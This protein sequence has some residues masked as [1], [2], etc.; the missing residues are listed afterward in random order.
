MAENTR[1]IAI[2]NHDG[3][4]EVCQV[5]N[6]KELIYILEELT[7]HGKMNIRTYDGLTVKVD[8]CTFWAE[9]ESRDC[10]ADDLEAGFYCDGDFYFMGDIRRYLEDEL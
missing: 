2:L 6:F 7:Y 4:G 3:V 8:G 10:N 1:Y 5:I 9:E